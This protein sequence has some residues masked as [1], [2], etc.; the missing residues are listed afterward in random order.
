MRWRL[1]SAEFKR[2]DRASRRSKLEQLVDE[3]TPVGVLAY[4][5]GEPVG[6]CSVAL[7]SSYAGLERYRAIPRVDAAPVWSDSQPKKPLP[8]L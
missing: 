5:D 3:G 8:A 4:Q 7:R 6:W 1:T 2:S